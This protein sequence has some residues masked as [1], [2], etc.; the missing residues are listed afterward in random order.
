MGAHYFYTGVAV[1][2]SY[3]NGESWGNN[4]SLQDKTE[5]KDICRSRDEIEL[6]WSKGKVRFR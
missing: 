3:K 6:P 4:L 2:I 5:L 1:F